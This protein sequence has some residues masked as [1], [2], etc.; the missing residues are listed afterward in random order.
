MST[1]GLDQPFEEYLYLGWI[2]GGLENPMA[3][4]PILIDQLLKKISAEGEFIR[5]QRALS[6]T[7]HW[8]SRNVMVPCKQRTM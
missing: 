7:R 5:A 1:L 3:E 6:Y 8:M 4:E 2:E